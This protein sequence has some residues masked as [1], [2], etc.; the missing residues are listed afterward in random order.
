MDSKNCWL[1]FFLQIMVDLAN[2]WELRQ[3]HS[4][5]KVLLLVVAIMSALWSAF[6]GRLTCFYWA[7]MSGCLQTSAKSVF[8][9]PHID[10]K[11]EVVFCLFRNLQSSGKE[12]QLVTQF[13]WLILALIF[14]FLGSC[15]CKWYHCFWKLA[16][17]RQCSL[18]AVLDFW[19]TKSFRGN[20][21]WITSKTWTKR[22]LH[23]QVSKTPWICDMAYQKFCSSQRKFCWVIIIFFLIPAL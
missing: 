9:V 2:N 13:L 11:I 3:C 7:G 19:R 22:T 6:S 17:T 21:Q 20:K 18:Q 1:S 16:C 8:C 5:R 14:V 15:H 10:D 23:I 4:S 12:M